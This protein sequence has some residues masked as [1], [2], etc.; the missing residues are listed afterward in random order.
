MSN[1]YLLKDKTKEI[2]L[3]YLKE[4]FI[5]YDFHEEFDYDNG[6]VL[7]NYSVKNY[8]RLNNIKIKIILD[9]F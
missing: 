7:T 2:I 4:F 8:L 6:S 9:V 3:K 5:I 1:S